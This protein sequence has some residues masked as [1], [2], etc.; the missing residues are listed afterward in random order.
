MIFI[1]VKFPVRP[2]AADT[3]MDSVA[4]FTAGTRAEPGNVMFE[5]SRSMDDPNE[6]VLVEGFRDAD[7]GGA[8][9][10]SQHFKAGIETMSD[11]VSGIPKII[12]VEVPRD[13]WSA[14]AEIQP[15]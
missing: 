6:Y 5:W 3:W 4:D 1:V 14:M 10:N 8:H 13:D 15:R 9:V 11:L 12:N 7:A 2:E